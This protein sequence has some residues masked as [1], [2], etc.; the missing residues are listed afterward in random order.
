MYIIMSSCVYAPVCMFR[1]VTMTT[2]P[3]PIMPCEIGARLPPRATLKWSM[4]W[5][6]SVV[7]VTHIAVGNSWQIGTE[8][9][10]LFWHVHSWHVHFALVG[11][12]RVRA[13]QLLTK[14]SFGVTK[15]LWCDK[16]PLV[17]QNPSGVTKSLWC[18]QYPI[19]VTTET[20]SFSNQR[21]V[22]GNFNHYSLL[23]LIP[24]LTSTS[25]NLNLNPEA[26]SDRNMPPGYSVSS[27]LTASGV[28]RTSI[29]SISPASSINT[30][31]SSNRMPAWRKPNVVP[32]IMSASTSK[33][34]LSEELVKMTCSQRGVPR[35]YALLGERG[36][37][38]GVTCSAVTRQTRKLSGTTVDRR[39]WR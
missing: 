26:V 28:P 22:I 21:G 33:T 2:T 31:R 5:R 15:S 27:A 30:N 25:L 17:W 34:W 11:K 36:A 7:Q 20:S 19:Q 1:G 29:F 38:K 9:N 32:C 18:P 37:W 14:S 10:T 35:G 39:R 8:M 16:V 3:S 4:S 24:T 23:P 12:E 13:F 6:L